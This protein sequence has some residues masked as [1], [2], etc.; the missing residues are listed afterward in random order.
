MC[1]RISGKLVRRGKEFGVIVPDHIV[2]KI[3]LKSGQKLE[4][5]SL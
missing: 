1:F 5:L 4:I 3:K 2:E